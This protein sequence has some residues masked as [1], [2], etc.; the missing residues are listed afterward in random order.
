MAL[1][2]SHSGRCWQQKPEL[3]NFFREVIGFDRYFDG[4]TFTAA[5]QAAQA[6]SVGLATTYT[7]LLLYN[8]VGSGVILVPTVLKFAMSVAPAATATIG[9]ISGYSA[10]GGVTAE[11]TAINVLSSQIGNTARGRARV[12]SAATIVAPVYTLQL[13]DGFTAAALPSP[14]T[15]FDLKG[16]LQVL[17][18]GF[19]AFGA[20]TAITGLGSIVWLEVPLTS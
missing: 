1:D 20:L 4:V 8:P 2:G 11:T 12:L 18:G 19:I 3:I 5:N 17:P 14:A 9:I 13:R 15:P 16:L 7:G 6:I 10:T